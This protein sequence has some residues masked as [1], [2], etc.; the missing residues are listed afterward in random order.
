MGFWIF[1]KREENEKKW[2]DLH[3]KLDNS[4]SN[5]KKDM[6]NISNWINHFKYTKEKHSSKIKEIEDRLRAIEMLL[7]DVRNKKEFLSLGELSKQTPVR[8]KRTSVHVQTPVQTGV[9]TG[10]LIVSLRSLTMMERAIVWTLL[11][12]DLKLNYNDLALIMGKNKST[13]RGQI[14]NIKQKSEGLISETL[15]KDGSKRF[16]ISESLKSKLL[17]E[18]K[19]ENIKKK[20]KK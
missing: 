8:F 4:F 16:H 12:T 15:D 13:V 2:K 11:N 10:N 1:G 3:S 9:Q 14:N 6:K 18:V 7:S 17:Q 5:I 20:N 19:K